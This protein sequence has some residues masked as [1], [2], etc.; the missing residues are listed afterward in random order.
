MIKNIPKV[1]KVLNYLNEKFDDKFIAYLVKGDKKW[2]IA[3]SDLDLYLSKK[4]SVISRVM[5]KKFKYTQFSM[6]I[7]IGEAGFEDIKYNKS[8]K[9]DKI[10]LL[11]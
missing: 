9:G 6:I 10:K 1:K 2:H 7:G 4:F 8:F 11:K 3:T 5:R